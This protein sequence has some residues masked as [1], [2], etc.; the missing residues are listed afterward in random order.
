M[1]VAD[2]RSGLLVGGHEPTTWAHAMRR[3]LA[4]DQ[5][6]ARLSAGARAHAQSLSWERTIGGLLDSYGAALHAPR[7]ALREVG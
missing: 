4:D 7:D 3:V 2:G 6:R 5:L 1:A